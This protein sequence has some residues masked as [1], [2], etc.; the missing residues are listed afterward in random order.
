MISK[1]CYK[2]ALQINKELTLLY[3]AIG[4]Q[5]LTSQ[6]QEGWGSKIIDRISKDLKS[7][8]PEMKGFSTQ[9]LKYMR[10]FAEEYS[11]KAISQQAIDQLPWGHI[12]TLIYSV[13]N[14]Q[15]RIFYINDTIENGWS[16]NILSMQIE[17]NLFQRQ[18]K[19]ITNFQEKLPT[20]HSDLA[21]VTLKNPYLFDFL[22]LGKNAHE[23]EIEKELVLHILK[24]F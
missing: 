23:R 9:N 24:N 1:S 16:R 2:T 5:I 12:I 6:S 11:V 10:R 8:F 15:E 22:S 20:P 7:E 4:Q 19:A 13:P 17:T 21:Q 18:G 3:H 14:Q